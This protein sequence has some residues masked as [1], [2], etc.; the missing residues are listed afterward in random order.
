MSTP[1]PFYISCQWHGQNEQVTWAHHRHIQCMPSMHLLGEMGHAPAIKVFWII[2]PEIGS[3]AVLG[4][5]YHSFKSYLYARFMSTFKQSHMLI[6]A[7]WPYFPHYL[8]PEFYVGT[9]LGMPGCSYGTGT[10]LHALSTNTNLMS[11]KLVDQRGVYFM[12]SLTYL[13]T[14]SS[15]KFYTPLQISFSI[16]FRF[17]PHQLIYIKHIMHAKQL[18]CWPLTATKGSLCVFSAESWEVYRMCRHM[19]MKR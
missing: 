19:K 7:P 16:H 14:P 13:C 17:S 5:K 11:W 12:N 18:L 15:L 4:N 1:L 3:E 8:Y 2:H 9:S 6:T 10:D